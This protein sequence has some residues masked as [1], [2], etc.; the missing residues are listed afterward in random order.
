M[1]L[2]TAALLL[3]ALPVR[4]ADLPA[5]L[6]WYQRVELSTPVSGVVESVNVQPGQTARKGDLL[7][8]LNPTLFKASLA[9]AQADSTRVG[10]EQADAN[11]ELSRANELYART[12]SSTTELDASKLRQARATA[13]VAAARARVDKARRLLDESEIRAPFDAL[14]LDRQAEPGMAVASQNQPPVLLTVARADLIIARASLT[15][16]KAA[17]LKPGG[18]MDVSAGGKTLS[19]KIVAVRA[20]A[21]AHYQLDVAIPRGNLIAGM[22]ASVRLP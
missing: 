6:D 7:L 16:D 22:T 12:V 14:I 18:H 11:K 13:Q 10:E 4:A 1:K 5:Q 3:A 19:G 17:G 8:R 21:D 9:E 15:A 2:L 20:K